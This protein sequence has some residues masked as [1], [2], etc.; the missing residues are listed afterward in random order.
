V[1]ADGS[2]T[3]LNSTPTPTKSTPDAMVVDRGGKFLYVISS[4]GDSIDAFEIGTISGALTPVPGSPYTVATPGCIGPF[5]SGVT[6][7][8]GRFLYTSDEGA[9][10]ISGYAIA[11]ETG[12]LTELARSP[13]PVSGGCPNGTASPR[14]ITT[15][16]TGRFL[17]VMNADYFS[18][19]SINAGNGVLT[20]VKDT[21][22]IINGL[23]HAAVR[24]DPSGKFLYASKTSSGGDKVVG[25][26]IDPISGDLTAL[27]GSPFPIGSNVAAFDLVVTP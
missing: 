9:S 15:E 10:E 2:V 12:T 19:Y 25:F 17:Y 11:G 27:P 3:L 6:D 5:P 14:G 23:L 1:N 21:T 24:A 13:F 18:I 7:L 8:F 4:G 26:S 20:H 22:R 16:P